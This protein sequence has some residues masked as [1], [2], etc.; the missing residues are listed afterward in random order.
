MNDFFFALE[1]ISNFSLFDVIPDKFTEEQIKILRE[2]GLLK[3]G[4]E[5]VSL[6][7]LEE[8]DLLKCMGIYEQL[9]LIW[10][11]ICRWKLEGEIN[12]WC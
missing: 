9:E 6:K 11:E 12:G 1:C 2:N 10:N 7:Q 4:E 8:M 5:L 3:P